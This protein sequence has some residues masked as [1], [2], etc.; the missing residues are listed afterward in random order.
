MIVFA[1]Q[2][3]SFGTLIRNQ[4]ITLDWPAFPPL[5]TDAAFSSLEESFQSTYSVHCNIRCRSEARV[6]CNYTEF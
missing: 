2:Q 5:P 4:L 3:C 6:A 1:Q